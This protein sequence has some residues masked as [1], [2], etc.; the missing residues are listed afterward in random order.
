M[1]VT[2]NDIVKLIHKIGKKM[3]DLIHQAEDLQQT[4]D[5]LQAQNDTLIHTNKNI[6]DEILEH[7]KELEQ[8]KD[9]YVN[10]N[11]KIS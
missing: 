9:F 4:I 3:D 8:I 5:E 1:K 7:I 6:Q 11:N 2:Q 10:S